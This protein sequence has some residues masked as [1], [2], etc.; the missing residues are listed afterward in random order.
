MGDAG[1]TFNAQHS[2]S[3]AEVH[4]NAR[5]W[6]FDVECSLSNSKPQMLHGQA[7]IDQLMQ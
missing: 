3:N 4:A 6:T 7:A 2:T 1:E 5:S